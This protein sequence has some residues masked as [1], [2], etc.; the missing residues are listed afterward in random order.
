MSISK[1]ILNYVFITLYLSTFHFILALDI[2]GPQKINID[3]ELIE[4]INN[5]YEEPIKKINEIEMRKIIKTFNF[6]KSYEEMEA[7]QKTNNS[8]KSICSKSL[9]LF[10]FYTI[11][12][13]THPPVYN[14]NLE[15][16]DSFCENYC[17]LTNMMAWTRHKLNSLCY[18]LIQPFGAGSVNSAYYNGL[19]NSGFFPNTVI[20]GECPA[21]RIQAQKLNSDV[22]FLGTTNSYSICEYTCKYS[23]FTDYWTWRNDQAYDNCYCLG[24]GWSSVALEYNTSWWFGIRPG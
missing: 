2:N 20:T 23:Q 6:T 7:L 18:C 10:N 11:A 16:S 21:L 9:F 4:K 13:T 3:D 5:Y 19:W 15:L 14:P 22:F 24:T 8:K 1:V 17:D 12:T